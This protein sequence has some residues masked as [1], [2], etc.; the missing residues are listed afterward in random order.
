MD[1]SSGFWRKK[2]TPQI[3]YCFGCSHFCSQH[4]WANVQS[5]YTLHSLQGFDPQFIVEASLG[6]SWPQTRQEQEAVPHSANTAHC[7]LSFSAGLT[8]QKH[9]TR[10][11]NW[12]P[13]WLA[14][15]LTYIHP[16]SI[17]LIPKTANLHGGSQGGFHFQWQQEC[18]WPELKDTLLKLLNLGSATLQVGEKIF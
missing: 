7:C 12:L 14:Y 10:R 11:C 1:N 18:K 16:H 17:I 5:L 4:R 15:C 2:K 9:P 8:L 6:Y 13:H 3:I